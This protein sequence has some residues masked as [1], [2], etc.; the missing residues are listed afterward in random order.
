[1][2]ISDVVRTSSKLVLAM[3]ILLAASSIGRAQKPDWGK[4]QNPDAP[5]G[6]E[7]D[8]QWQK[9]GQTSYPGTASCAKNEDDLVN[10]H[11]HWVCRSDQ[12]CPGGYCWWGVSDALYKCPEGK[13][14][15]VMEWVRYTKVPCGKKDWA[16]T[17][18]Y[19]GLL[20]ET[21]A[22]GTGPTDDSGTRA[23]PPTD[24]DQLPTPASG[25]QISWGSGL[26]PDLEQTSKDD[27]KN[28]SNKDKKTTK[29]ETPKTDTPPKTDEPSKAAKTST[30]NSETGRTD[31]RPRKRV[32]V[33]SR[34]K[35]SVARHSSSSV[36]SKESTGPA[37]SIGV[38]LGG[39]G[40]RGHDDDRGSRSRSDR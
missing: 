36:T 17:Q 3:A 27:P 19:A 15:H 9:P 6:H 11:A 13:Y 34:K 2:L 14:M 38:G 28:P 24:G 39:M 10:R 31:K 21:W 1:M 33:K 22:G 29:T 40:H 20:G 30:P 5:K 35:T 37:I 32:S 23:T 4:W 18:Y 26:P 12:N 16:A 25:Q 8:P 7:D